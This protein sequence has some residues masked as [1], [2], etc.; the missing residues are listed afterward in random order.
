MI[1]D[2]G[3]YVLVGERREGRMDI[4][5]MT[6]QFRSRSHA[7][8]GNKDGVDSALVARILHRL[9]WAYKAACHRPAEVVE[10]EGMVDVERP[11]HTA[12]LG[13]G[14]EGD[15]FLSRPVYVG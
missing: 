4:S 10:G 5:D 15:D 3:R 14:R 7:A 2:F 12:H 13:R 6:D 11:N 1:Y 8:A 9:R